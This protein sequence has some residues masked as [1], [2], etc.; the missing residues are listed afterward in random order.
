MIAESAHPNPGSA[1]AVAA[2]RSCPVVDNCRGEG[3]AGNGDKHDWRVS[4][5]CPLHGN[6]AELVRT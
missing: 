3:I 2:G 6:D 4:D 5:N 1:A